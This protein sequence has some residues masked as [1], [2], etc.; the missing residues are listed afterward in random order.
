[1]PRREKLDSAAILAAY[2][3]LKNGMAV[4]R[5][6]GIG[7]TT[8]YKILRIAAHRCGRCG[9][10]PR[11]GQAYCDA[12]REHMRAKM[13][14]K[15]K[16]KLRAGKCQD[17]DQP[18]A[19]PSRSFCERHRLAAIER[20]ERYEQRTKRGAPNS[21][22][23][24]MRQRLR[25]VKKKYGPEGLEAFEA[26]DGRCEICKQGIDDCA[27]HLHHIDVDDTNNARSNFAVLCFYCHQA[28]HKL[29]ALKARKRFLTWFAK[30]YARSNPS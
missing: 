18:V 20:N 2:D 1:M 5:R 24:D 14:E 26:A 3:E 23:P 4:A 7:E 11:P 16:A 30:N 15:R 27:I 19:P 10:Q 9:G 17:C 28:T 22:I 25:A 21:G 13:A 29:L 6:F 8:I 12:C